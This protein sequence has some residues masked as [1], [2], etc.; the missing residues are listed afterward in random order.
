LKEE[1]DALLNEAPDVVNEIKKGFEFCPRKN[2][3]QAHRSC[4]FDTLPRDATIVN[5][6]WQDLKRLM[7]RVASRNDLIIFIRTMLEC[8][9]VKITIISFALM[10]IHLIKPYL[11]LVSNASHIELQEV[12]KNLFTELQAFAHKTSGRSLTQSTEGAFPSLRPYFERV[13]GN[14]VY[15]NKVTK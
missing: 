13:K 9:F 15:V 6:H 12:F 10:G 3:A 7:D 5:F 2:Y 4:R 11:E 8:D 1:F 14:K